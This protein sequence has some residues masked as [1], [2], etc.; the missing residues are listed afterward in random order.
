MRTAGVAFV[1]ATATAAVLTPIVR[2]LA[3]RWGVLDH[4]L[5]SRKIHGKPIPRLG[6]IAMVAAFYAPLVALFFANSEVG[7]R[8]YANPEKALGLFAGGLAIAALG[9]YD[10]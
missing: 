3:H 7:R 2:Q 6:G 8:F 10:D 9:I 4:A 1:A 5:S